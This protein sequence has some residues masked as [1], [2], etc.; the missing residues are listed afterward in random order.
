MSQKVIRVEACHDVSTRYSR[1]ASNLEL[2]FKAEIEISAYFC[3]FYAF[4]AVH[5]V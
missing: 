3:V 5:N 1:E 4:L 2:K